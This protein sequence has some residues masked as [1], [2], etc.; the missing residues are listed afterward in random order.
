VSTQNP[1]IHARVAADAL[2][3]LLADV[4]SGRAAWTDHTVRTATDDFTRISEAITS[5]MEQMTVALSQ[6][7]ARR[8]GAADARIGAL[9][10]AAQAEKT[11][12]QHLRR[13]RRAMH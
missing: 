12:A 4:Q 13:A 8:P 9:H 11:T 10:Q 6:T 1:A 5:A 7:P 3:R 2:A